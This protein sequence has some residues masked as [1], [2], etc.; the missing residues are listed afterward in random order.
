MPGGL[1]TFETSPTFERNGSFSLS[2]TTPEQMLKRLRDT[3]QA[4][5]TKLNAND[6]DLTV[7]GTEEF[8]TSELELSVVLPCFNEAESLEASVQQIKDTFQEHSIEGE[9]VVAD[10]GSTDGSIQIANEMGVRVVHVREKGYGSVLRGG[11]EFS[12]GKYVIIGD[13]DGSFDFKEIP[14]FLDD[15]REGKA[16]VHGCRF[17]RGGGR[18]L[19]GA[20]SRWRR[21]IGTPLFSFVVRRMFRS[22]VRDAGCGFR[23][24][25]RCLFDQLDLQSSGTEFSAEMVVKASLVGADISEVPVTFHPGSSRTGKKFFPTFRDGWR[26]VRFFLMYSTHWLFFVPAILL[27]LLGMIGYAIA[28][29]GLTLMGVKL[30]TH[31]LLIASLAGLLGYQLLQFVAFAK[32]FA[33]SEGFIS[34]RQG[35]GKLFIKL[36]LERCLLVGLITFLTGLALVAGAWSQWS[37]IRFGTLDHPIAMQWLIPGFSLSIFGSQTILGSFFVSILRLRWRREEKLRK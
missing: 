25:S 14:R 7:E 8:L 17:S 15:L 21:W 28:L 13:S 24:F 4:I 10:N 27:C 5:R 22:S 1:M 6:S 32:T 29:S 18:I 19:S 16:Y 33:V 30:D 3:E 34:D 31:A 37:A 23:G 9:I 20:M 2:D 26:T 12:Q 36:N 11:I 35:L